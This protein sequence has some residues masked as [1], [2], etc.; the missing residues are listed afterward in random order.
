MNWG[1]LL[2]R[3]GSG[4]FT[5]IHPIRPKHAFN[6]SQII[7]NGNQTSTHEAISERVRNRNRTVNPNF[8][9][10]GKRL[11]EGSDSNNGT[12]KLQGQIYQAENE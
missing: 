12:Q 10:P 9:V 1:A 3:W 8:P 7:F 6:S 2:Y 11:R 4:N 5:H